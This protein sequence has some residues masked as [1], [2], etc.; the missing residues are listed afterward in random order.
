M[1]LRDWSKVKDEAVLKALKCGVRN[2]CK[3]CEQSQ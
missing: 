1:P 2:P 3:T